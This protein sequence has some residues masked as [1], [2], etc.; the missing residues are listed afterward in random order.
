MHNLN[1]RPAHLTIGTLTS[2]GSKKNERVHSLR[3]P[4]R[5]GRPPQFPL[6]DA[7]HLHRATQSNMY[8]QA[9]KIN[10][11]RIKDKVEPEPFMGC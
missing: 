5:S 3:R 10:E 4:W 8:L 2:S 7:G 6:I 1:Q 9:I 11:T